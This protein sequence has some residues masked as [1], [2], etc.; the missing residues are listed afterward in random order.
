MSALWIARVDV[1][2]PGAYGEYAKRATSAIA[3]HGGTFLARG[4]RFEVLEGAARARNVVVRFPSV[5]AAMACYNSPA[6]QDALGFARTASERDL[7][8]VEE[9]D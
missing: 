2:D 9:L 6:Y 1:T 7:I 5:E 4:G 3:A 8:V